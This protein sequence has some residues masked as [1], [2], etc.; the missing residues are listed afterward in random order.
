MKTKIIKLLIGKINMNK[1]VFDFIFLNHI[2]KL[3]NGKTDYED[4]KNRYLSR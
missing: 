4:L 3:Y 1:N 2:S